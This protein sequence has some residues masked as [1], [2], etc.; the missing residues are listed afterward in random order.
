MSRNELIAHYQT[1]LENPQ[2]TAMSRQ[3]A[4]S[5]LAELQRAQELSDEV[6]D[7][8]TLAHGGWF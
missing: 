5:T 8:R 7:L 2:L 6:R 3:I 1:K 4:Q